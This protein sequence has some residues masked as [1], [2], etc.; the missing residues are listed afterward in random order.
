MTAENEIQE[1]EA[2]DGLH[3]SKLLRSGQKLTSMAAI[4]LSFLFVA[5]MLI[6]DLF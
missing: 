2:D 1:I 3:Q 4:M 6:S 5:M